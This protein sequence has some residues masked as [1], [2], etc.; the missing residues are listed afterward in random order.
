MEAP[1]REFGQR[2]VDEHPDLFGPSVDP[3]VR[4]RRDSGSSLAHQRINY[5]MH[6][7]EVPDDENS[8]Y[9]NVHLYWMP[10]AEYART[11]IDGALRAFG[12]KITNADPT[13]DDRVVQQTRSSDWPLRTSDNPFDSNTVFYRHVDSAADIEETAT[14]LVEHFSEF[15]TAYARR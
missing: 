10:P 4:S 13:V 7:V 2:M 9:L 8:Q 1:L 14:T 12:Y 3:H 6:G 5:Q 15:G 11:D